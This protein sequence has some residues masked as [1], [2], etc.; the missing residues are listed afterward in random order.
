MIMFDLDGTLVNTMPLLVAGLVDLFK[1]QLKG[2]PESAELRTREL[3]RLPPREMVQAF[4]ELSG[5]PGPRVQS[6]FTDVVQRLPAAVFPEVPGVLAEL[7][8]AGY[9][10]V[11]SS[12]TPAEAIDRRLA[13]AGLTSSIDLALGL[14]VPAGITKEEHP[15]LAAERLGLTAAELARWGTF[16]GDQPGDMVLARRQGMLAIGRST[17]GNAEQLTQAG[18]NH[19]IEDLTEL[20]ALLPPPSPQ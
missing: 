4:M 3:L 13:A 11:V 9:V 1:E 12:T 7:K 17:A 10:L 5:W 19:V 18:A 15:R 14:N 2:S 6:A 20:R 16:V 8:E